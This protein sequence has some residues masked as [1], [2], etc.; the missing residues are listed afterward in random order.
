MEAKSERRE[1]GRWTELYS[2]WLGCAGC[3][4]EV[5]R[6]PPSGMD[7]HPKAMAYCDVVLLRRETDRVGGWYSAV[8]EEYAG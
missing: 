5:M 3:Y 4:L 2:D 6:L 7:W 8:D 1:A